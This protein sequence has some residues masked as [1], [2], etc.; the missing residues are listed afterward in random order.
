M[1][2]AMEQAR[3][4]GYYDQL[5]RDYTHRRDLLAASLAQAGFET[6]PIGGSYFLMADI[7]DRGFDTDVA[8]CEWLVADRRSRRAAAVRLLPGPRDRAAA[9]P[10]LLRQVRRDHRRRRRTD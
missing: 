5:K 9:G 7:A 4:N 1:A 6:L 8:F 2:S 3:T 10:L